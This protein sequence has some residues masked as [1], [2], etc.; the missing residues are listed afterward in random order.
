MKHLKEQARASMHAKVKAHGGTCKAYGGP[1]SGGGHHPYGHK[2]KRGAKTQVNV[3]VAPHSGERSLPVLP[4]AGGAGPAAGAAPFRPAV[5]PMPPAALGGLGG[6]G[7]GL[8]G[9]GAGL[10]GR[11]MSRGGTVHAGAGTGEGRLEKI[12]LHEKNR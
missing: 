5:P 2:G 11:P 8:G 9:L 3:V 1:V 7:A 12:T 10:P 6:A 4:V